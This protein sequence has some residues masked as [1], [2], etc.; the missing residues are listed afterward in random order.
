M[1]PAQNLGLRK[2]PFFVNLHVGFSHEAQPARVSLLWYIAISRQVGPYGSRHTHT[3]HNLILDIMGEQTVGLSKKKT[4]FE[5]IRP[6]T[7]DPT[8]TCL[9][10]VVHCY[11]EANGP[12]WI[13]A[14]TQS[15]FT[16]GHI[17]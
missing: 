3:F 6:P 8:C 14:R 17:G 11:I 12:V 15:Q 16:L 1:K 7:P 4:V 5:H 9:F 10:F 13:K 2:R